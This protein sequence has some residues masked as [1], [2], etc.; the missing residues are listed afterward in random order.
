LLQRARQCGSVPGPGWVTFPTISL[1]LLLLCLGIPA[2]AQ[3]RDL[4]TTQVNANDRV[5]LTGHHPAW[6]SIQNDRGPVPDDQLLQHLVIILAR[7][8]ELQLAFEQFLAAQQDPTSPEFHHWLTPVEIG[9]QFGPSANDVAAI[10]DWLQS[11][12]L[13]VDSIASSRA[14]IAFSGPALA[15]GN[16]FGSQM[17]SFDVNGEQRIS[18]ADEPQIPAALSGIIKSISG[19]YEVKFIP[20]HR[21]RVVQVPVQNLTG[22]TGDNAVP[23]FNGGGGTHYLAPADFAKIYDISGT[24]TGANQTIAIIGESN[25]DNADITNFQSMAGL[26]QQVPNVIIPPGGTNPGPADT[27]PPSSGTAPAAQG[28]ATLDVTRAGSIAP[29]A[30][31]DLVISGGLQGIEIATEW[32]VD[33]APNPVFAHIMSISFAGCEADGGSSVV[34]LWNN[35]FSEAAGEGI[36]V[37][38]GSGDAGAAGCDTF[39]GTP[40]S[41]QFLSVNAICSSIYATCVGGTEFAD[42]S[43]PGQYWLTNDGANFESAIQYIPEG[44]WNEPTNGTGGPQAAAS[45]GGFSTVIPT[46]SYQMGVTGVPTGNQ[47]RYTPDVAFSAADHD[48]YFGCYAAG[49]G[50]CVVSNNSFSF[51]VFSGTSAAAPDMAGI[52]ALLDQAMGAPQG[53]LNP[54]LYKLAGTPANSVFH[55]VTVAT[56]AVTNCVVTTPSMCNNSTPSSTSQTGGLS[57]YLVGTGYD[58]VTGLGSLDVGNLLLH[59]AGGSATTVAVSSSQSPSTV[60]ASVTFTATVSSTTSGT[61]TGAVAFLDNGN[62]IGTGILN[63]NKTTTLTTSSLAAGSQSI[64]AQY[65]GDENFAPSTSGAISQVVNVAASTTTITPSLNPDVGGQSVTFTATVTGAAATPTGT[66]TFLDG[67]NSIGTGALTSGVATITTQ[68]LTAASHTITASYGGDSNYSTS[69]SAP[70]TESVTAAGFGA[71]PSPLAV[72]PPNNLGFAVTLYQATGSN[73]SYQ[74][75]CSDPLANSTCSIVPPLSVTPNSAG[76]FVNVLIGTASSQVPAIPQNRWPRLPWGALSISA[77]L[78]AFLAMIALMSV[79]RPRIRFAL[80]ASLATVVLAVFMAGCGIGGS[81]STTSTGTP[82]GPASVVISA[83]SGSTTLSVTVNFNVQ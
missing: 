43:N 57:G 19:L 44:G 80:R 35:L 65:G 71:A 9:E 78:A 34:D 67:G 46:P 25:V 14:R 20:A 26:P 76:A 17:H 23:E 39:F 53:N 40:P 77:I 56:S 75:S 70:L 21:E 50:S 42:S 11:Q 12:N 64:T 22:G 68:A 81:T 18:I 55:D 33:P 3:T 73:L 29:G 48:G 79:K 15:I 54:N 62:M 32:V 1:I 4:V 31:I 2:S 59:W 24:V 41:N 28:E 47:G 27:A 7:P 72:T 58:E 74:L 30:T 37:F 36:S 83:V 38:V 16:A 82:T 63:A 45:G 10:T 66:V 5:T 13:Q 60:G 69:T 52:A 8:P 51:V 49:Q 6:A 61:P